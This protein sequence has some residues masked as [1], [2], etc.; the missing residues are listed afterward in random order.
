VSED[1]TFSG[2]SSTGDAAEAFAKVTSQIKSDMAA[3]EKSAKNIEQHLGKASKHSLGGGGAGSADKGSGGTGDAAPAFTGSSLGAISSQLGGAKGMGYGAA[4]SGGAL[5]G[6]LGGFG[7]AGTLAGGIAL[8]GLPDLVMRP[9]RALN[10]EGARFGMAQAT[11]SFGTFQNMMNTARNQFNVQNE[12][13]FM[14]TMVYGTQRMGMVG[15]AGGEQRAASQIGGYNTLAGMAGIDQSMVP[16]V[17]GSMN[18]AQAYYSSMAAGVATRNP[19][20]GELLGIESQVN[21][22]WGSAGIQGM[23]QKQALDQID[24]NYGAGS[25]GR[26]Q[27]EQMYGGDQNA[28]NM[29]IEGLRIRA[30]QGG[31]PLKENQVQDQVKGKAGGLGSEYTQGMEGTRGLESSKMAMGAEYLN[32]ATAGIEEAAK[33]IT[34]AVDLLTELEGPL[35]DMVGAYTTM[36]NQMDVFKTEL[37]R[38]TDGVTSFFTGLPGLFTSFIMGAFGKSML[39]RLGIGAAT[40]GVAGSALAAAAPV[41]AVGAVAAGTVAGVGLA[42]K[43][44]VNRFTD[45]D[46]HKGADANK[47]IAT[48]PYVPRASGYGSYSKGEWFVESDQV[49][50]I[51]YGEMVVPNRIATAVREELAVGK[52][53]PVAKKEGTIVNINL[54]IQKASDQE[55]VYFA[56]KV[57]RL[58]EDDRE[59]MSIGS[60]RMGYA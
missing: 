27:L 29:V 51:H 22:L 57:K 47:A 10:M 17:M 32:D 4:F 3:M 44:A 13:A 58:I 37:P 49:A 39:A 50:Q 53:S 12:Q 28:V 23:G 24:I 20:T 33:H 52:T 59:L 7:G 55:A 40:S 25:A 56:Q 43:W 1:A 18:S 45:Y 54:T 30:R 9:E 16:G 5:A 41:L 38:A 19:V 31:D 26:A 60:G 42:G 34:N 48:Q 46:E 6:A 15:L 14:N 35:R 2:M 11:G 21:Q 8:A 36:A